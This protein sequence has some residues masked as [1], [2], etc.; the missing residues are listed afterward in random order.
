MTA[1]PDVHNTDVFDAR[2]YKGSL[3][4]FKEA[5]EEIAKGNS[6]QNLSLKISKSSLVA[7]LWQTKYG[8]NQQQI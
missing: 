8:R 6:K 7:F 4:V 3:S 2:M 1:W 5:R